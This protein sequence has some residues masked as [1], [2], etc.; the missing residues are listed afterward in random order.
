MVLEVYDRNDCT[1]NVTMDSGD[2]ISHPRQSISREWS[3]LC[4]CFDPHFEP[5]GRNLEEPSSS[6][7]EAFLLS[8]QTL[9]R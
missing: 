2:R 4:K 8:F 6:V 1:V 7:D 9:T 3:L 5:T